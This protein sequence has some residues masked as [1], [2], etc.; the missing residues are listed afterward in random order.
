MKTFLSTAFIMASG[1]VLFIACIVIFAAIFF[2]GAVKKGRT[3][4]FRIDLGRACPELEP[5]PG[6]SPGT[7]HVLGETAKCLGKADRSIREIGRE[8]DRFSDRADDSLRDAEKYLKK[9]RTRIS[10]L[11]EHAGVSGAEKDA[12]AAL[13]AVEKREKLV[14]EIKSLIRKLEESRS[15]IDLGISKLALAAGEAACPSPPEPA[16]EGASGE[17]PEGG[18]PSGAGT[19]D[20]ARNG[21]NPP[22]RES[23]KTGED[24]GG[25]NRASGEEEGEF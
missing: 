9:A 11:S 19:E 2:A 23:G 1:A 4:E 16:V 22:G 6:A 24:S 12:K 3:G 20:S 21:S 13:A 14:A 15:E 8:A 17:S 25:G 18:K 10:A 5:S 7:A